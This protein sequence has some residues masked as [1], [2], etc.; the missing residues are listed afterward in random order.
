MFKKRNDFFGRDNA[1][2]QQ[3]STTIIPSTNNNSKI[4]EVAEN[5]FVLRY[6]KTQAWVKTKRMAI[7]TDGADAC[8][9]LCNNRKF[10]HW[11][12]EYCGL[13]SPQQLMT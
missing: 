7:I 3:I 6:I 4:S 8:R 11:S 13:R 1:L 2:G 9:K 10:L 5:N 12:L